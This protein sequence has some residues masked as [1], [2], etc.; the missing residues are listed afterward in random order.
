MFFVIFVRRYLEAELEFCL[1]RC[2]VIPWRDIWCHMGILFL[3]VLQYG[4][5]QK[6]GKIMS[7]LTINQGQVEVLEVHS[8]LTPGALKNARIKFSKAQQQ[9]AIDAILGRVAKG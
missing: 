1:F 4:S 7:T 3:A 5:L 6:K 8:D 9:V 2:H